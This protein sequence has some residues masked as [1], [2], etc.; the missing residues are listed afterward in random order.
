MSKESCITS[1]KKEVS[2]QKLSHILGH[3]ITPVLKKVLHDDEQA[4]LLIEHRS[5]P[6]QFQDFMVKLLKPSQ[7][8]RAKS[9]K[10]T[11]DQVYRFLHRLRAPIKNSKI[12]SEDFE[13]LVS[14]YGP[15][16]WDTIKSMVKVMETEVNSKAHYYNYLELDLE[17]NYDLSIAEVLLDF[18]QLVW[19]PTSQYEYVCDPEVE[20]LVNENQG[21]ITHHV[22]EAVSCCFKGNAF[23]P[24]DL[25][26]YLPE[27]H[28]RGYGFAD[29]HTTLAYIK[30]MGAERGKYYKRTVNMNTLFSIN[31]QLYWFRY[32]NDI[33]RT[34]VFIRPVEDP[35]KDKAYPNDMVLLVKKPSE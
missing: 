35:Q 7:S 1:E 16:R 9:G 12:S 32:V 8:K 24:L 10:I 19:D 18:K 3:F 26:E 21:K 28:H 2:K 33:K 22:R 30:K 11:D 23:W 34:R 27:F 31:K 4:Q 13:L 5:F 20:T 25:V 15:L 29:L 14:Q 6:R 17:V